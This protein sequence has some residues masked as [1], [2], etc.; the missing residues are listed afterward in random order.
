MCSQLAI[1]GPW[2]QTPLGAYVPTQ[3]I[4]SNCLSRPRC[5]KW[6]PCRNLFLQSSM[7]FSS[8]K[9]A[10][11]LMLPTGKCIERIQTPFG[12]CVIALYKNWHYHYH[13]SEDVYTRGFCCIH[14]C[15]VLSHILQ[16]YDMVEFLIHS[17][18]QC[19]KNIKICTNYSTIRTCTDSSLLWEVIFLYHH[20]SE[21]ALFLSLKKLLQR[22]RVTM[23]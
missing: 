2:V 23:V 7:L 15:V 18:W 12:N 11:G 1:S 19:N 17:E 20:K 10:W 21:R 5:S 8:K 4:L 9:A 6:V 22:Q 3:G 16:G 14:L 13:Y